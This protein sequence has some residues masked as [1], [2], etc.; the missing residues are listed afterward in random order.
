MRSE[1]G[2]ALVEVL[3]SVALLGIIGVGLLSAMGSASRAVVL[4]D[5]R[6]TAKNLAETQMEYIKGLAYAASYVPAPIALDYSG[7][8]AGIAVAPLQDSSVQ[9]ITVT[10]T[11]NGSEVGRLEDYRAN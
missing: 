9:K 3:V 10:I 7:Y 8:A 6:V 4:N 5:T 11:R 2:L 1:K